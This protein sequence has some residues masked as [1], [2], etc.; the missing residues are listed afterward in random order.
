MARGNDLVLDRLSKSDAGSMID[1]L[2]GG[3]DL[4][5]IVR[6]DIINRADGIPLFVQ[7]MTRAVLEAGD[8]APDTVPA[9]LQASLLSRLDRLGEAKEVAQ[10][11]AAIGREFSHDLLACIAAKPMAELDRSLDRLV[12]A[13]LLFR[14]QSRPHATYLFNHALVQDAAYGTLLRRRAGPSMRGSSTPSRAGSLTLCRT[15]PSLWRGIA[16]RQG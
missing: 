7:E 6:N 15:S 12:A 9:T 1:R 3:R 5:P 8:S 4:P 2:A 14:Q 10:L 16:P 11:G 13:G